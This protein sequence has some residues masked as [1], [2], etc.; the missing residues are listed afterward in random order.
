MSSRYQREREV[1]LEAVRT[2]CLA[3]RNVRSAV[4]PAKLDKSDRS[5]VTIADFASQAIVCRAIRRSF[6][7]DPIIAEEDAAA[8]QKA[9]MAEFRGRIAA[10]VTAVGIEADAAQVCEWIDEGHA[11]EFSPRFWT[12][13][14]IDGTKGFLRG[15]QYAVALALIVEGEIVLGLLGCP[16][17]VFDPDRAD[18]PVGAISV[19]ERGAGISVMAIDSDETAD[20]RV[21]S[22]SETS[23]LRL[24]ESV[25]SGHSSHG[26]SAQIAEELGISS[27][28]V[29]LDSQA[30][31][32]TVARGEAD[33]YL[34]LPTRPGYVERIWDHAGGVLV[35]EEAGGTVT[36]VDGKPLDFT[37][38]AG[39]SANRGVVA[40]NGTAHE[41]V[42]A[43]VRKAGV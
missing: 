6:P 23:Q 19:A 39:L 13:D 40:S 42:L 20:V 1:A 32:A 31:Y 27:D 26:H 24:C 7:D 33:L 36:D 14:P 30:K 10:E 35:V 43:A 17:L 28:P 29:R 2:A 4:D 3:C 37:K 41:A 8:L 21:S 25:E 11:T 18:G 12:L 38:G 9:E 34:R 22:T 15:G 5:P 16:N